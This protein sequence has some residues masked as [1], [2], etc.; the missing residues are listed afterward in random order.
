MTENRSVIALGPWIRCALLRRG[1]IEPF[2]GRNA[3]FDCGGS[4]KVSKLIKIYW[5]VD[6]RLILHFNYLESWKK[7]KM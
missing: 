4:A 1:T 6:C 7:I 3:Y 5:T 2:M